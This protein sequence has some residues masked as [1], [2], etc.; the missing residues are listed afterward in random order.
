MEAIVNDVVSSLLKQPTLLH[1]MVR[2]HGS[3]LHIILPECAERNAQEW[4]RCLGDVYPDTSV[5]F[6]MKACKSKSLTQAFAKQN[7]GADV[8]S[9]QELE[10]AFQSYIPMDRVSL[11]G[12]D[13]PN[14]ELALGLAHSV[15]MHI[16]SMMELDRY[17]RLSNHLGFQPRLLLRLKPKSEGNSR[18]GM[19]EDELLQAAERCADANLTEVGLSFHLNGYDTR[20]RINAA[21]EA[22]SLA[23]PLAALGLRLSQLDIGG[24]FVLQYIREPE[25]EAA[26]SVQGAWRGKTI[27]E[28]YPYAG[29]PGAQNGAKQ[30]VEVITGILGVSDRRKIL[31]ENKTQ[32]I[33]EPGRALLN[34]CGI[35]VFKV[36]GIKPTTTDLNLV[37]LDGLSMSLSESW[38]DSDF[39]PEPI[40]IR[41]GAPFKGLNKKN[42]VLAG[43][44]CL[45]R[46]IIRWHPSE[47]PADLAAGDLVC[48]LNTAGYQMD[49]NESPFHGIPLPEKISAIR[50][51]DS[52]QWT[53][54]R[55]NIINNFETGNN[56]C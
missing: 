13:K 36:L 51:K 48:F 1:Q 29:V 5:R 17:L 15:Q 38:F 24:G 35:T 6:A 2:C 20:D 28:F 56:D 55:E 52:W 42:Y 3:P 49:S 45:E 43:R 9:A 11:T 26:F 25:F 50:R 23:R 14:H 8:A 18:F 27:S 31:A 34:Q 12:P 22:I 41:D 30:A 54:D 53:T 40:A 7:I 19:A 37:V 44:S 21:D 39:V 47:L 46:D 4:H 33:L 32:L 16:D 10:T